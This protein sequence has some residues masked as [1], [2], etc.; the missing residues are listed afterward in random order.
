MIN[1][2]VYCFYGNQI[3]CDRIF[4]DPAV[5]HWT[6]KYVWDLESDYQCDIPIIASPVIDLHY[7]VGWCIS[8]L[9]L[10]VYILTAANPVSLSISPLNGYVIVGLVAG[11][12]SPD[13]PS[14]KY[15]VYRVPPASRSPLKVRIQAI[16]ISMSPAVSN[17][18]IA[19]LS[20]IKCFLWGYSAMV[21]QWCQR[22][23]IGLIEW[24]QYS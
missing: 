10:S 2:S 1:V 11:W 7:L 16:W 15:D 19:T 20:T 3:S 5:L 8:L 22:K 6:F 21:L 9:D 13:S 14:I 17:S 18:D 4:L 24:S 23:A 12:R